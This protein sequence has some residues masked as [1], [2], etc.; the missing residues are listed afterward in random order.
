V[1][2]YVATVIMIV[3][4]GMKALKYART[5][6]PLK[7]PVSPAPRTKKGVWFRM[8]K[9]VAFFQSLFKSNRWI[10][11]F[12]VLFHAGML[13]VLLRHFR[14]FTQPV[15]WWVELIQPIGVYA[16]FAMLI[17]LGG[18]LLRRIVLPRIRY[19]SSP[20]DYLMLI[21]FLGI[22]ISGM[23]MKFV[24]PV[25][26]LAVKQF[27]LGLMRFQIHELPTHPGVLI[28]LAL[29]AILMIIFPISKLMHAPG[30]FFAPSRTQVDNARE[31]RHL[32][33]WAKQLE[34]LP[35]GIPEEGEG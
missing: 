18:L 8:F 19:I 23:G 11:I 5:P 17:G 32:S 30:V 20:S 6:A 13:L 22:V 16:S 7:I 4:T 21:L 33:A 1:L 35:E 27:F 15:W 12:A 9:E 25:D 3:G 31:F 28:H 24:M 34:P 26:I 10:W 29:V 14:Y 2:F